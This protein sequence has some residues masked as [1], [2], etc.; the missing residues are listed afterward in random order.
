MN[1]NRRLLT[2]KTKKIWRCQLAAAMDLAASR[3]CPNE[4][5]VSYATLVIRLSILSDTWAVSRRSPGEKGLILDYIGAR[6][7]YILLDTQQTN[8]L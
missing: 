8:I 3:R 7:N 4:K 5:D 1:G 2:V 6:L